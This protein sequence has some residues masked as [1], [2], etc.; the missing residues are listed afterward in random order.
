MGATIRAERRC[1]WRSRSQQPQKLEGGRSVHQQPEEVAA[2]SGNHNS[3]SKSSSKKV[4]TACKL[5]LQARKHGRMR[6]LPRLI[7][8]KGGGDCDELQPDRHFLTR[9]SYHGNSIGS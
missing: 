5:A 2:S 1:Q 6:A 8:L 3:N 7:M 4:A 9:L